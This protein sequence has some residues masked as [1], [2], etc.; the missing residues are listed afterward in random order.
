MHGVK[1]GL[2]IHLGGSYAAS[3]RSER[4]VVLTG[5]ISPNTQALEAPACHLQQ[6]SLLA[7]S[8]DQQLSLQKNLQL[9]QLLCI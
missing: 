5:I 1:L 7:L 4:A 9:A 6:L 3:A 8:V 2:H